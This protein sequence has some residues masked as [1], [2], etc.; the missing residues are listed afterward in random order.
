MEQYTL[1]SKSTCNIPLWEIDL[2]CQLYNARLDIDN[3]EI[4]FS[5]IIIEETGDK[6]ELWT[7]R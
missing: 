2:L 7:M 4:I 1:I 5:E 3:E 6:N